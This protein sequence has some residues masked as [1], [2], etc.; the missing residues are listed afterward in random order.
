MTAFTPA[1]ATPPTSAART[2]A[3]Q[4]YP[5]GGGFS[6]ACE[7]TSGDQATAGSGCPVTDRARRAID[8]Y[9]AQGGETDRCGPRYFGA[10]VA[11]TVSAGATTINRDG[12]VTVTLNRSYA[13]GGNDAALL[14]VERL[15]GRRW[16]ADDFSTTVGGTT[17]T[18]STSR[19]ECAP[20]R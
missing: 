4:L 16:L 15:S 5:N 1:P 18:L 17:Y 13:G 6:S 11:R 9:Y 12:S 7:Q 2:A 14:V 19:L 20:P 8:A 3:L 10:Q